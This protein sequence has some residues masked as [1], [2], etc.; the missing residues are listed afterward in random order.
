MRKQ[1]PQIVPFPC[2]FVWNRYQSFIPNCEVLRDVHL[3]V[4]PGDRPI[5]LV[6]VQWSGKSTQLAL[7]RRGWR[8]PAAGQV[9]RRADPRIAYLKQEFDVDLTAK[10]CAKKL[11]QAFGRS[12]RTC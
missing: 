11:F 7:D 5:G 2:A 10:R 3:E 9:V 1:D 12:G 6:G 4:K 8:S